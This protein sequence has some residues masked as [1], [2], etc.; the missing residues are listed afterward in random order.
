[1]SLTRTTSQHTNQ[2]ARLAHHQRAQVFLTCRALVAPYIVSSDYGVRGNF[3]VN[4]FPSYSTVNVKS[5]VLQRYATPSIKALKN[6][7]VM[8]YCYIL[9]KLTTCFISKI[10]TLT[11]SLE[12]YTRARAPVRSLTNTRDT[13]QR[14]TEQLITCTRGTR[15]GFIRPYFNTWDGFFFI[16]YVRFAHIQNKKVRASRALDFTE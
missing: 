5:I 13:C 9:K 8:F 14:P 3:L 12:K 6:R 4:F 2:V 16:L 15:A 7:L 1:M 11:S 10:K